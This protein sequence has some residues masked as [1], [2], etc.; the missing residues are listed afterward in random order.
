VAGAIHYYLRDALAVSPVW[1]DEM[2]RRTLFDPRHGSGERILALLYDTFPIPHE[3]RVTK[4]GKL[5]SQVSEDEDDVEIDSRHYKGASQLRTPMFSRNSG[6]GESEKDTK[7]PQMDPTG[8]SPSKKLK[9][10]S[11]VSIAIDEE[12]DEEGAPEADIAAEKKALTNAYM[13]SRV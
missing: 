1:N 5:V 12:G 11:P 10:K 6:S 13:I 8:A 3:N 2:S 9:H 4:D 7:T